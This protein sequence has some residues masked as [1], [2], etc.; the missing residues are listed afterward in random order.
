[1]AKMKLSVSRWIAGQ[2]SRSL[3]SAWP[4]EFLEAIGSCPDFPNQ[5]ELRRGFGEDAPRESL[6]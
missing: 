4:P 5:E 3:N 1:M 6:D 2:V